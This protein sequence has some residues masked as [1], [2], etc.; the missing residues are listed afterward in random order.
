MGRYKI[1]VLLVLAI[2]L[3]LSLGCN[4]KAERELK[5]ID[6]SIDSLSTFEE[7]AIEID[8][9]EDDLENLAAPK[10]SIVIDDFGNYNN[11]MLDSLLVKFGDLPSQVAFAILPDLPYSEFVMEYFKFDERE[12]LLHTPMEPH[13]GKIN[14]GDD[15]IT[16][17]DDAI[18]IIN[19]LNKFYGQLPNVKGLNNHMGSKSTENS[20]VMTTVL[21]WCRDNSLFFVDSATTSKSVA[22]NLALEI[23]VESAQRDIFLDV[24]NPSLVTVKN[25]LE[26]MKENYQAKEDILVITHASTLERRDNL[27]FFINECIKI[28]YEL[29]PVSEYCQ[30]E[31][32]KQ[33]QKLKSSVS[34]TEF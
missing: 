10:L 20:E 11:F 6:T 21:E 17:A 27:E 1:I 26:I 13:N 23:G 29:I 16:A 32:V 34:L 24:P 31:K 33:L 15:V 12:L 22:Y 30:R 7:Q 4:K 28:G 8:K 2:T 5:E 14:A 18:T 3:I 9:F 25:Y 19:K